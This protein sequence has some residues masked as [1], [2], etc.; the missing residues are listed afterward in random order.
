MAR[1]RGSTK[2]KGV[3]GTQYE[4]DWKHKLPVIEG[5]ARDGCTD[6][7]IAEKMGIHRATLYK[8]RNRYPELDEALK[9]GKEVVDREVENA[10]L[11][12]AL[13]YDYVEQQAVKVK[14]VY[15]LDGKRHEEEHVEV[16]EV[17]KR[18]P[19]DTTAQIFWLKNR[20]PVDWRDR[21]ETEITGRDGGP[22]EVKDKS[23]ADIFKQI[24]KYESVFAKVA[25]RELPESALQ[26]DDPG[27]P[28]DT[29]PADAETS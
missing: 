4:R 17:R 16:V 6:A 11:R 1:K 8:W 14:T 29:A 3:R 24:E 21:R 23:E 26:G 20:K 13:G 7:E 18:R 27:E 15:Y 10:L 2:K 28:V 19:A 5:W 22:I 9:R 12:N 25:G